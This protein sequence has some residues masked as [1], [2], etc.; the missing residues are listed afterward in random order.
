MQY[1]DPDD[2]LGKA[3]D[4]R[5]ARRL[6]RQALPYRKQLV[7]TAFL[8]I[9]TAVADLALPFLFGLGLDVVTPSSGRTFFGRTGI[10]ALDIL[11][12]VLAVSVLIRFFS[13]YGQTYYTSWIGQ[14]VVLDMRSSLFRHM[15]RLSIRFIDQRGV[16]SIM[17]RLQNDV[18]VIND[19]FSDGLVGIMADFAIL[20]GIII[21][22]MITN[23]KL[24]LLTFA[25]MPVMAFTMIWWR[26]RAVAAYRSMRITI[27]RVNANLA[28]SIAGVRVVQ[29]FSREMRNMQRFRQINGDNLDASVGA[30]KLSAILF[31][32]VQVVE[33]VATGLVLFIG[34][35]IILG[36]AAFTIGELFTFVA[37]ISRFYEPIRD[38]SQRYNTMQ[39]AMVAGERIFGLQDVQPEIVDA[40]GAIELPRVEGEVDYD[41]VVFG[42]ESTE[43]LHGITLHVNPGDSVAF[44][45]ETGAGKSSMINLLS[46]FYDVWSGEV[47][48]DGHDIR[49]VT[50]SSLRSQFG[51]VLQDTFLFAG[52]VRENIAYGRP[53]ASI[54][55]VM[56]AAKAVGAHE[57]IEKLPDKY[58]TE[59]HERGATLSVGQRQLISFARALLSDPRIIVLDEATSSVDTET[60]LLIQEALRTLLRGRTSFIIAHRLSTIKTVSKVVVMDQGRVIEM[61]THD[62]LLSRRGAYFNLYT[63]QFRAQEMQ[64]AADD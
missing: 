57:F 30:A 55:Q 34:G 27:A 53:D 24:A 47:R 11:I 16:G 1:A 44:V 59:V 56:D 46:R 23:T 2:I 8:M 61:G 6:A 32:I 29:A 45:G 5:I 15:Q 38:L 17:S 49:D 12:P 33:A 7:L 22:M 64:N 10:P 51:I 31:P 36:G 39:A 18:S 62:D 58:D 4:S 42:Y 52:T 63:M 20:V 50:Q 28:E 60:E 48:I 35:R 13:Y 40:P 14:R 41:N 54:E 25:V 37:Y 21:V 19:L 9:S 3:Y 26:K 43:V